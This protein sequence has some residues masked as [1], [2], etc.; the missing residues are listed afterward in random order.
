VLA[1][2][3]ALRP[4]VWTLD[5]WDGNW[6]RRIAE[7]G[8]LLV[9]G[10]HSDPA[11]FPLYPIILRA[12]HGI[13]LRWSIAGPVISNLALLVGL[14]LFHTLSRRIVG[15]ELARRAT[16]YLAIFPLAY[17]FSMAYP[18]SIAI[19][20]IAAAG[21][22]ALEQR[23]WL[24]TVFAAA[25]ALARPEGVFLALPLAGIAWQQ[26]KEL[27]SFRGGAALTAVL[28]P[29][30][31]VAAYPL[32]LNTVLDD[33]LAWTEAQ[34]V[35]G[36]SF[37]V[38]GVFTA[39]ARLPYSLSRNGWI[40]RD[41]VFFLLYLALLLVAWRIR[42]ARLWTLAAAG[43]VVVPVFSGVFNS[44]ARF[45]LLAP[46]LFW[47]LASLTRNEL[48]HRMV[49]GASLVLLVLGTLSIRYVFP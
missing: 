47:G 3:F 49:I 30:A 44:A 35:W 36:R 25:A 26:R 42:P 7:H 16:T 2:A 32:Y 9:P 4:T 17:V 8:Y 31:A 21:L 45:G 38:T 46:P 43:I 20:L 1:S 18:E 11:F 28:S 29:L 12:A 37:H 34:H 6:Y 22:A 40:V 15:D 14:V 23:W 24:A 41:V 19:V 39:F 48:A 10:R 5:G 27:G 13:G 33:P